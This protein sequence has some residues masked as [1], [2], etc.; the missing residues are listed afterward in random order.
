MSGERQRMD[1]LWVKNLRVL[2]C[3]V[4]SD[5]LLA[6]LLA[7]F[8]NSFEVQVNSVHKI[9][10]N[11][12]PHTH[13]NTTPFPLQRSSNPPNIPTQQSPP[14][15][16]LQTPP[17]PLQTPPRHRR[18]ARY[19]AT[20]SPAPRGRCSWRACDGRRGIGGA[21]MKGESGW[22]EWSRCRRCALGRVRERVDGVGGAS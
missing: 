9:P 16:S 12:Q 2:L 11:L 15:T 4:G 7:C 22:R 5:W 17:S 1:T 6:C 18:P 20:R 21:A 10:P 3:R 14:S 19:S 13:I 8:Q